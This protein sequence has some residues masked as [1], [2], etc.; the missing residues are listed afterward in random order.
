MFLLLLLVFRW[1]ANQLVAYRHLLD[2]MYASAQARDDVTNVKAGHRE[3]DGKAF[4]PLHGKRKTCGNSLRYG[5]I[6]LAFTGALLHK[7]AL[8]LCL[9]STFFCYP[10]GSNVLPWETFLSFIPLES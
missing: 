2:C 7:S 4:V 9:N 3:K 8:L 5:L 6:T 1:F 10:R